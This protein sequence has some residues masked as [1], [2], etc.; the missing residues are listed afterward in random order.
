LQIDLAELARLSACPVC[1]VVATRAEGVAAL[2]AGIA[3][4]DLR[5]GERTRHHALPLNS[6]YPVLE[7]IC[8]RLTQDIQAVMPSHASRARCLALRLLEGDA[9]AASLVTEPLREHVKTA[10]EQLRQVTGDDADT[11]LA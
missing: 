1:G 4:L 9:Y 2:Q 6:P 7:T 10:Q 8:Q 3:R 5:A 11:L